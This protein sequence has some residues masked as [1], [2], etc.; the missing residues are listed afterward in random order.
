MGAVARQGASRARSLQR[1]PAR[2]APPPL[3]AEERQLVAF[4]A[5]HRRL[6]GCGPTWSE[7]AAVMGWPEPAKCRGP[8]RFRTYLPIRQLIRRG[9]LQASAE[10][11]SLDVGPRYRAL[12]A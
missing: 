4:V 8:E 6:K 1:H 7:C 3:T 5:T 2:R 10:P 9:W 12:S 11:R